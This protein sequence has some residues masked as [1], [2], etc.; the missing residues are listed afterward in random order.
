[1]ELANFP[2][3]IR[4]VRDKYGVGADYAVKLIK[5]ERGI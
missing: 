5:A 4:E 3:I 1:M 2:P